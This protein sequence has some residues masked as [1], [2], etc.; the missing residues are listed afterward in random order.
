LK[1]VALPDV[2]TD[3]PLISAKAAE[4]LGY[5]TQKPEALLERILT[6]SSREDDV[7]L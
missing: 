1:G 6:A 2:W 3:I 4:R 5:P 7:V